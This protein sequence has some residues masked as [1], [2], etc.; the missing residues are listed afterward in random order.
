MSSS[1]GVATIALRDFQLLRKDKRSNAPGQASAEASEAVTEQ[2][3]SFV[4]FERIQVPDVSR[5][6]RSILD[7]AGAHKEQAVVVESTE[8]SRVDSCLPNQRGRDALRRDAFT[9]RRRETRRS[10]PCTERRTTAYGQLGSRWRTTRRTS[11]RTV[12][13]RQ[14]IV[15]RYVPGGLHCNLI[16]RVSKLGRATRETDAVVVV[17]LTRGPL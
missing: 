9:P 4:A 7:E 14:S 10:A 5:A 16:L 6:Q 3:E 12:R 11:S 2:C 15:P 17:R 1:I 8:Q 13:T